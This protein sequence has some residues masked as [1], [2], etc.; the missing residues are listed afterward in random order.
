M[1]CKFH[2]MK[3]AQ[4]CPHVPVGLCVSVMVVVRAVDG[5]DTDS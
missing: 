2:G 3:V 5:G 1:A 4:L